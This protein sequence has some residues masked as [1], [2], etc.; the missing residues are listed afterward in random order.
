[1]KIKFI[2]TLFILTITC[3]LCSCS[4]KYDNINENY[5]IGAWNSSQ[6][7]KIIL[8]PDGAWRV[9]KCNFGKWSLRDNNIVWTYDDKPGEE[10]INPIVKLKPNEF[11]VSE[12]NGATTVFRRIK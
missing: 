1:M 12:M 4:Q 2:L 3:V 5:F 9:S 7:G 11:V 8:Y 6:V 10:D